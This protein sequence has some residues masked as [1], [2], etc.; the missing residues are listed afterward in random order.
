[1]AYCLR[2]RTIPEKIVEGCLDLGQRGED[3]G[4]DDELNEESEASDST[5]G[6]TLLDPTVGCIISPVKCQVA[7]K[8]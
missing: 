1:M 2:S 4:S 3:S 5:F 7:N 6:E 8:I